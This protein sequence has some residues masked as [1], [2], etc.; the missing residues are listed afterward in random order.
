MKTIKKYFKVAFCFLAFAFAAFVFAINP[1]QSTYAAFTR[2]GEAL[3]TEIN[4]SKFPTSVNAGDGEELLIP[5]LTNK[6]DYSVIVMDPAGQKHTATVK[7]AVPDGET[8]EVTSLTE[9]DNGFF[10]LTA[11]G[12]IKVTVLNNGKYKV[13]YKVGEVYSNTYRVEVKNVSYELSFEN[14]GLNFLVPPTVAESTTWVKFPTA[15]VK[16]IDEENN[17]TAIGV[18]AAVKATFE[19]EQVEIFEYADKAAAEAGIAAATTTPVRFFQITAGDDAGYYA[20]PSEEG[21]MS[22]T[23]AYYKA[24]RPST[25]YTMNVVENFEKPTE[26]TVSSPTLPSFELGD[27]DIQLPKLNVSDKYTNNVAYNIE[28]VRIA[29]ESNSKVYLELTN[30]DLTFDMTTEAFSREG[31]NAVYSDLNGSYTITYSIVD[32][33]GNKK[34][35]PYTKVKVSIASNPKVYMTYNYD[36]ANINA[37]DIKANN[38]EA[39]LKMK[40]HYSNIILPAAYAEDKV[41]AYNDLV[42]VRTLIDSSTREVYYVD[43][44]KYEAGEL[45]ALDSYDNK[46]HAINDVTTAEQINSVDVSKAVAFRFDSDAQKEDDFIGKKFILRYTAYSTNVKSRNGKLVTAASSEY[47][48]EVTGDM[49][50]KED[51]VPGLNEDKKFISVPEVKIENLSSIVSANPNEEI[52]VEATAHDDN[53]DRLA[54]RVFSIKGAVDKETVEEKIYAGLKKVLY[55]DSGAY[56]FGVGNV[57][58][59]AEIINA[60]KEVYP[61]VYVATKNEDGKFVVTASEESTIVAVTINDFGKIGIAT[62]TVTIKDIEENEA[63]SY[64]VLDAKS[65]NATA[66]AT[67]IYELTAQVGDTIDLPTVKFTDNKDKSLAMNVAYYIDSPETSIGLQYLTPTN[68]VVYNN[69]IQ[70][71]KIV[72]NKAGKYTVI[73]SA[74][75]DAGNISAMS[76]TFEVEEVEKPIININVTGKDAKY[77]DGVVTIKSGSKVKIEAIE[78]LSGEEAMPEMI[79]NNL[80]YEFLGENE[81]QFYGVGTYTIN[82]TYTGAVSKTVKVK[83]EPV[84]LK[85]IDSTFD[86]IDDY[87]SV[88]EEVFL[89][90]AT[91]NDDST[92]K[93]KVTLGKDGVEQE[94]KYVNSGWTFKP[95]SKGVYYVTYIAENANYVLDDDTSVF[96]INVGDN[97]EPKLKLTDAKK[98]ELSKDIVKKSNTNIEYKLTIKPSDK[99]LIVTIKNGKKETVINTGLSITDMQDGNQAGTAE[100]TLWRSLKPYLTSE[101][102]IIQPGEDNTWTITG[103]GEVVLKLTATDRYEKTGEIVINFNVVN[104]TKKETNKDTIVGIVLIVISLAVLGGVIA[105]FAFAGKK[106]GNNKFKRSKIDFVDDE[107]VEEKEV[108]TKKAK[109]EKVEEVKTE[110]P[111]VEEAESAEEATSEDKE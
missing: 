87:A 39:D 41:T 28:K 108:S 21:K 97:V 69:T 47:T 103:T 38:Y 95:T 3:K 66:N 111:V 62:K 74:T 56:V 19:G 14:N 44:V 105:Y 92:I 34:D 12:K 110:E 8:E 32:A 16:E 20:V 2:G 93:V 80:S 46:N 81:Y 11:N 64:Q 37:E 49:A 104:E 109:E 106:G 7:T 99:E 76:F 48:F 22:I 101:K 58:D 70:N 13:V 82:Y 25:T 33:Y 10:E 91:T 102:D 24:N 90:I 31:Y 5:Q 96:T 61:T 89:P 53:D 67:E 9:N 51:L 85:W 52:V 50:T 71:G 88:N 42:I 72:A 30:N 59:N 98:T 4:A 17:S 78:V 79:N 43:N 29:H 18:S 100:V 26:L 6:K 27:K 63:P 77:V 55:P 73:Y 1:T 40:Y 107:V 54:T 65:F 94:V 57:L 86:S 83:V 23:Y 45:V 68:Y 36:K 75:D 84:E 60:I 15:T 35:I